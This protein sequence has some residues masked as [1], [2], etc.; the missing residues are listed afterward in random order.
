MVPGH[1]EEVA[2]TRPQDPRALV[3]RDQLREGGGAV[4]NPALVL[5]VVIAASIILLT[6]CAWIFLRR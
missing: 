5:S 4:S 3:R 2:Q 6:F 1:E